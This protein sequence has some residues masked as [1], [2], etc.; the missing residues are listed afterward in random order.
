ML[1]A[2]C[3]LADCPKRVC[4]FPFLFFSVCICPD[5]VNI[6][7]VYSFVFFEVF[8][9]FFTIC[10]S[11]WSYF[12][13]SRFSTTDSILPRLPESQFDCDRSLQPPV[14]NCFHLLQSNPQS[15]TVQICP[16]ETLSSIETRPTNHLVEDSGDLDALIFGDTCK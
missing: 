15:H 7:S 5:T 11:C 8:L 13:A 9:F 6:D 12:F 14:K 10:V 4:L 2:L 16:I 1:I 3:Y